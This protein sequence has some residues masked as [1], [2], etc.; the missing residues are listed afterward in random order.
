VFAKPPRRLP[1]TSGYI[2]RAAGRIPLQ[3]AEF[4]WTADS[5][6]LGDRKTLLRGAILDDTL[7]F[8]GPK[9]VVLPPLQRAE[10]ALQQAAE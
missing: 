7:D 3:G 8:S 1:V 10:P 5:N 4:P 2:L 9:P 6:Y